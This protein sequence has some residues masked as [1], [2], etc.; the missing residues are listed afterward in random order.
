[1]ALEVILK[2]PVY[3]L[4]AEA[5]LVKVKPGYARNFLIPR[6]LAVAA[7]AASKKVVESLKRQRA[8]R[9]ARE[10]NDASEMATALNKLTMTF[11][12]E[13]N[14]QGKVFGAVTSQD[15]SERLVTMGHTVDKKKIGTKP[16]KDEG[17]HEVTVSLGHGVQARLK[18]VVQI[19]RPKIE[20][21]EA[22]VKKKRPVKPKAEK[23]E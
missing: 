9:E 14:E 17:E 15:I 21:D 16:I 23:S 7:S 13:A 12:M 20:E 5:D 19:N 4:G 10:L 1:M 3:G 8:E 22:P 11:P 6:G 18:V 2:Q